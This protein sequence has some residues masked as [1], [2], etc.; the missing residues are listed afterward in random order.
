M[1][2]HCTIV[3]SKMFCEWDLHFYA[4]NLCN[5]MR[6]AS[7]YYDIFGLCG[8][9]RSTGMQGLWNLS[10]NRWDCVGHSVHL[11]WDWSTHIILRNNTGNMHPMSLF[12][13]PSYFLC[14]YSLLFTNYPITE[15]CIVKSWTDV[16]MHMKWYRANVYTCVSAA[17][18][19]W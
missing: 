18:N 17:F 3:H 13:Q 14:C 1:H 10:W 12:A 5:L 6:C 7:N 4:C 15:C 9:T 16:C 2:I 8:I 19:T 11:P